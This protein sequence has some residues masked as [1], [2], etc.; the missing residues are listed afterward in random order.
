M[1]TNII[2]ISGVAGAGKDLFYETLSEKVASQRFS[3][4]DQLKKEIAP[5]CLHHFGID[6]LSC[7]REE[8]NLIR[9]CLVS[10]ASLKRELTEGR[11]WINKVDP[12]VKDHIFRQFTDNSL[13]DFTCITDIRYNQYENDEVSWLK[14]E[15]KGILVH[16]SQFKIINSKRIFLPPA[17][18]DEASQELDL[19][20]N[21]DYV[22]E[23]Q[24]IEGPQE[25]VK[26]TFSDSVIKDFLKNI[27]K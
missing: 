24:Y 10:H 11:Y 14:N 8:K 5:Y 19:K 20:A 22:Y 4:G 13:G 15:L 18:P 2:G 27:K 1:K 21:A 3:L 12:L 6:P 7:S 17:N 16:V 26:K 9:R 23:C 25:H